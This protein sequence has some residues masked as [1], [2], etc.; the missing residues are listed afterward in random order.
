MTKEHVSRVLCTGISGCDKGGYLAE[1]VSFS[2]ERDKKIEL[3]T[4]GKRVMEIAS[5]TYPYFEPTNILNIPQKTRMS[6]ANA[7]FEEALRLNESSEKDTFIISTHARFLWNG[8]YSR[9]NSAEYISKF[10]P[11]LFVTFIDASQ[12]IQKRLNRN[13][14]WKDQGLS[15][16]QILQWQNVEVDLTTEL[17]EMFGKPHII[18]A[19]KQPVETMYKRIFLPEMKMVYAAFPMTFIKES[20]E[21]WAKIDKYVQR[22]NKY[23]IVLDPRTIETEEQK[24]GNPSKVASAHT[25]YRDLEWYIG[26]VPIVVD[27]FPEKILS[28]GAIIELREAFSTG[29]DVYFIFPNPRHGPFEEYHAKKIFKPI[30]T[31]EGII[32][33]EDTFFKYVEEELGISPVEL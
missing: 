12:Q 1:L 9:S 32:S 28:V 23:F 8:V 24:D 30:E 13:R 3:Y 18:L 29:K 7:A 21:N 10:D 16:D 19:R 15:L 11:D 6:F 20:E 26:Q 5:K 25:V 2:K 33:A 31:E 22:L 17:A 14:Q 4:L 27:F